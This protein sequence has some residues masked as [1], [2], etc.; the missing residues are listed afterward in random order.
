MQKTCDGVGTSYYVLSCPS[1]ILYHHNFCAVG[2]SSHKT[3]I[4]S[5][6]EIYLLSIVSGGITA[7]NSNE[8]YSFI[9]CVCY[10]QQWFLVLYPYLRLMCSSHIIDFQLYGF[11]VQSWPYKKC[12]WLTF[13]LLMF[14]RKQKCPFIIHCIINHRFILIHPATMDMFNSDMPRNPWWYAKEP[15]TILQRSYHCWQELHSIGEVLVWRLEFFL[16]LSSEL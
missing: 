5:G 14:D 2:S 8:I 3:T 12:C 4:P 6:C 11:L 16:S 15:L 10:I 13:G 1:H 9:C 7:I